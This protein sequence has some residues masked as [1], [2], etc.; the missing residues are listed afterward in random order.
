MLLQVWFKNRRAKWRKQKR[1]D[2][3]RKSTDSTGHSRTDSDESKLD[4]KLGNV[5][6]MGDCDSEL[7]EEI[8]VTDDNE[9][10]QGNL[11]PVS[12]CVDMSVKS[13]CITTDSR[14]HREINRQHITETNNILVNHK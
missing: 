7:D 12:P 8:S 6:D 9:L 4:D 2:E 3:A 10:D 13:R 1:E 5:S 14:N 11:S